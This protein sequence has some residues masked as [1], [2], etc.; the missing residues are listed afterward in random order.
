[1]GGRISW[2]PRQPAE[3]V[4]PEWWPEERTEAGALGRGVVWTTRWGVGCRRGGRT[5]NQARDTG[6]LGPGWWLLCV[7]ALFPQRCSLTCIHRVPTLSQKLFQ[8]PGWPQARAQGAAG[9]VQAWMWE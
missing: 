3:Q 8:A 2:V 4:R 7:D 5:R 1:M 9:L 6:A